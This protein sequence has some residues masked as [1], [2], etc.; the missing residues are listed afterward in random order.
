MK[1]KKSWRK[2]G[3][4]GGIR[5]ELVTVQALLSRVYLYM[6]DY[7][8]AAAYSGKVIDTRRHQ[9][10][11]LNSFP[12]AVSS[13]AKHHLNLFFAFLLSASSNIAGAMLTSSFSLA[14]DNYMV[15]PDLKESYAQNDLRLPVFFERTPLLNSLQENW[16][17]AR[18]ER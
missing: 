18:Y 15:S 11:D 10:I 7:E 12:T 3:Q 6:S 13:S 2:I 1:V 4:R 17:D 16:N 14:A 5:P 9:L 8:K